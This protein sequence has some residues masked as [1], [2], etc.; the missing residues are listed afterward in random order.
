MRV[1]YLSLLAGMLAACHAELP[2]SPEWTRR[3]SPAIASFDDG[4]AKLIPQLV[5]V[6]VGATFTA[7]A[8]V[9]YGPALLEWTFDSSNPGV[10]SAH[11]HVPVGGSSTPIVIRGISAGQAEIFCQVPNFGRAASSYVIGLV[12]VTNSELPLPEPDPPTVCLAPA[13]V[14][15]LRNQEILIGQ[16]ATISFEHSGTSPYAYQWSAQ[17]VGGPIAALPSTFTNPITTDPLYRTT[18][19][20]V[21][22]DNACGS[23]TST[24]AKMTVIP[25]RSRSVRH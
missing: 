2:T 15:P 25:A 22:V 20:W 3:P 8:E 7:T 23:V 10:A 21:R 1:C 13:I 18:V 12:T 5:S 6:S 16:R 17:V 24:A 19:F 14:S 9:K 4:G 11:A